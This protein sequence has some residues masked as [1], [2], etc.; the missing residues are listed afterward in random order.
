MLLL[1]LVSAES[2]SRCQAMDV[3]ILTQRV[4]QASGCQFTQSKRGDSVSPFKACLFHMAF[5]HHL[6][7]LSASACKSSISLSFIAFVMCSCSFVFVGAENGLRGAARR[8]TC[9]LCSEESE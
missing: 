2:S 5:P 8:E 9:C 4:Y 1:L 7:A 3:D 6:T